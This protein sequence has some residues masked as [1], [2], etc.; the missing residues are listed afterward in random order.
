MRDL[1]EHYKTLI[2]ANLFEGE[3]R[4][5][6]VFAASLKDQDNPELRAAKERAD[7][8][9]RRRQRRFFAKA[10]GRRLSDASKEKG[11]DYISFLKRATG[12][13]DGI[14]NQINAR[15]DRRAADLISKRKS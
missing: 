7:L 1:I 6:R 15:L 9:V 4:R 11:G 14:Q 8:K 10:S 5:T 12:M 2:S 3:L 13:G